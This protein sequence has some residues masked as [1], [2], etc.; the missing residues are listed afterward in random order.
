MFPKRITTN[1]PLWI[2]SFRLIL[3]RSFYNNDNFLHKSHVVQQGHYKFYDTLYTVRSIRTYIKSKSK[4]QRHVARF[5]A[6]MSMANTLVFAMISSFE[7]KLLGKDQ[8]LG[9]P[10]RLRDV[11]GHGTASGDLEKQ[12][13]KDSNGGVSREQPYRS[14]NLY[15]RAAQFIGRETN[16]V[17][18]EEWT[19]YKARESSRRRNQ[20]R[21]QEATKNG[22]TV[23]ERLS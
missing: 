19:R 16:F 10:W 15:A 5:V 21:K 14:I 3:S 12:G 23:N 6:Q 2:T 8:Q 11:S 22:E 20:W 17:R 13:E 4:Q 18:W 1:H 7:K 9:K